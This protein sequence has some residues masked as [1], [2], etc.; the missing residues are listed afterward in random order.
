MS[1]HLTTEVMGVSDLRRVR[2]TGTCPDCGKG[3]SAV[4]RE[5]TQREDPF[6]RIRC[7]GCETITRVS[8]YGP[9]QGG[10]QA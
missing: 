3:V 5:Q 7:S 6:V 8:D 10:E 9:L 2:W 4:A 1:S